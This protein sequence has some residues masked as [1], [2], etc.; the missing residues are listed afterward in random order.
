MRWQRCARVDWKRAWCCHGN[1]KCGCICN[2]GDVDSET[3]TCAAVPLERHRARLVRDTGRLCRHA[4]EITH[5]SHAQNHT[6]R[7]QRQRL[8]HMEPYGEYLH[9]FPL[10]FFLSLQTQALRVFYLWPLKRWS[11]RARSHPNKTKAPLGNKEAIKADQLQERGHVI[12][13]LN[14]LWRWQRVKKK[15]DRNEKIIKLRPKEKKKQFLWCIMITLKQK[16]AAQKKRVVY[17]G[18]SYFCLLYLCL[19]T[20]FCLSCIDFSICT[21]KLPTPT[22]QPLFPLPL[23]FFAFILCRFPSSTVFLL[24][25]MVNRWSYASF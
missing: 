9:I 1:S 20:T 13:T 3:Y 10:F 21:S 17:R 12:Q 8:Q 18:V 4:A 14:L 2:R 15:I 24:T 16:R 7:P 19:L 11:S 5:R 6:H 22:L 23:L 25:L